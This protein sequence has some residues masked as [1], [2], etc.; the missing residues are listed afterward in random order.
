MSDRMVNPSRLTLARKRAGQTKSAL[1]KSVGVDLR[2]ISAYEAGEYTPA[3]HTFKKL[4]SVLAFPEEF[5]YGDDLDEPTPDTAS[6]RAMSKMTASK[7]DMALS[8]GALAFHL[9]AWLETRFELP[10]HD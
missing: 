3:E 1:A 6:F 8:A 4:Q 10:N 9:N 2:T 7:R 5:F